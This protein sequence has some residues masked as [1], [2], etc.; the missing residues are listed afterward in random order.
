MHEGE[1]R[2]LCPISGGGESPASFSNACVLISVLY[3]AVEPLYAFSFLQTFIDILYGYFGALSVD[4]LRDN[5]DIVYQVR[6]IGFALAIFMHLS[7][8]MTSF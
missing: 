8:R 1:L 4:T 7:I 2:F 5:F 3:R 6:Q